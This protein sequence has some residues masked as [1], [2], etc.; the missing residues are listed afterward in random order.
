MNSSA[1]K[2]DDIF[3]KWKK[4]RER[5]RSFLYLYLSTYLPA[6]IFRDTDF[7]EEDDRV[8]R[9]LASPRFSSADVLLSA[10]YYRERRS[11]RL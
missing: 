9:H 2:A 10:V 5:D 4:E 1:A 6:R 3:D 8:F 7:N 11:V